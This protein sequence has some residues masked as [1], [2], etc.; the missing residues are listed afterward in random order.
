[1]KRLGALAAFALLSAAA[2]HACA[3]STEPEGAAADVSRCVPFSARGCP[4]YDGSVGRQICDDTGRRYGACMGCEDGDSDTP[5]YVDDLGAA[6]GVVCGV[7]FPI[8]C[9]PGEET[10][11]VRSLATDT[12]IPSTT[13]C[14]CGALEC[15]ATNVKCDGPEDCM[16]DEVC[17]GT[18]ALDGDDADGYTKFECAKSCSQKLHQHEACH[19]GTTTCPA[20]LVC[21]NSQYLT[22]M[23][24]CVDP[25]SL[26]Q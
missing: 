3:G 2:V 19:A 4:C 9:S 14:S 24:V 7:A 26:V 16:Q 13:A 25:A 15:L 11:C 1:M 23:Q 20:G 12:C 10:C 17:C 6:S 5:G 8:L 22:N 18:P 21:S